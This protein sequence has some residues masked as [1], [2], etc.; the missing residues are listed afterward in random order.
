MPQTI[1]FIKLLLLAAIS[2]GCWADDGAVLSPHHLPQQGAFASGQEDAIVEVTRLLAIA[3]SDSVL[4]NQVKQDLRDSP[5]LEHKVDFLP[6]LRGNEELRQR[7]NLNAA[8]GRNE[9]ARLLASLRPME[10]YMPVR[11]HRQT[12]TGGDDLVV[13][14]LVGKEEQ[15]PVGFI[16]SGEAYPLNVD[17]PPSVPVLALVPVETDFARPPPS[18]AY[19]NSADNEGRSIGIYQPTSS[20]IGTMAD[21]DPET[22][23]EPCDEPP[24]ST[25]F[26]WAN[27]PSGSL[28]PFEMH[29]SRLRA[30]SKPTMTW[31]GWQ[32]PNRARWDSG[33]ARAISSSSERIPAARCSQSDA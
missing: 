4:R 29:A 21:C 33:T 31:W 12:W 28:L 14:T 19:T 2:A 32:W 30:S 15:A 26:S 8:N 11:S 6:Y 17:E 9:M 7:M 23:I 24:P 27:A 1:R 13:A 20:L 18:G 25:G 5:F 10:L 16:I 22:A 3:M